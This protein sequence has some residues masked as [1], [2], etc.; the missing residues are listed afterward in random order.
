MGVAV[1]DDVDDVDVV[2]V[3]VVTSSVAVDAS[4]VNG[5]CWS[6]KYVLTRCATHLERRRV[7]RFAV[8][9]LIGFS[10]ATFEKNPNAVA[11]AV[12]ADP[13]FALR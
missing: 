4:V 11:S 12:S 5:L 7:S 1:V 3:V 9:E 6:I 13:G 10:L 2:A 8:E